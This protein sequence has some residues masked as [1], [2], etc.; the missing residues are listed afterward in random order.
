MTNDTP[1][2]V[3]VSSLRSTRATSRGGNDDTRNITTW[4]AENET[5]G[6][7]LTHPPTLSQ[8]CACTS[9]RTSTHHVGREGVYDEDGHTYTYTHHPSPRRSTG[10]WPPDWVDSTGLAVAC[11][12]PAK[13]G[14]GTSKWSYSARAEPTVC[15]RLGTR[16]SPS[17][18]RSPSSPSSPRQTTTKTTSQPPH[19]PCTP[20]RQP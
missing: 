6:R 9:T 20:Y 16:R 17:P 11:G 13:H 7:C 4:A 3:V 19:P 5:V 18:P 10:H 15:V 2:R 14:L 1:T 12:L 8:W